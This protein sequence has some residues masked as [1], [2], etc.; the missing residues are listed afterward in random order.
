LDVHKKTTIANAQFETYFDS[1]FNEKYSSVQDIVKGH[2]GNKIPY[3]KGKGVYLEHLGELNTYSNGIDIGP[4]FEESKPNENGVTL[5]SKFN[6]L[7]E[8]NENNADSNTSIDEDDDNEPFDYKGLSDDYSDVED[9]LSL[10]ELQS[11][12]TSCELGQLHLQYLD[13]SYPKEETNC[14]NI[15]IDATL[16]KNDDCLLKSKEGCEFKDGRKILVD[17]RDKLRFE[18][19]LYY[20]SICSIQPYLQD[21]FEGSTSHPSFKVE[22]ERVSNIQGISPCSSPESSLINRSVQH[23]DFKRLIQRSGSLNK[24]VVDNKELNTSNGLKNLSKETQEFLEKMK[25][26]NSLHLSKYQQV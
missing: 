25:E 8:L 24:I 9:G 22:S 13:N 12:N 6:L 17:I 21:N 4:R 7:D 18:K 14:N 3:E 5:D 11:L 16:F 1:K 15:E 19:P 20:D 26:K 2:L 23:Q 10:Q